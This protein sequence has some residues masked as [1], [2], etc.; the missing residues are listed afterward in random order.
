MVFLQSSIPIES[1][2]LPPIRSP[3]EFSP[4]RGK[5]PEAGP[6]RAA[7][8]RPPGSSRQ[9]RGRLGG[10]ASAHLGTAAPPYVP[11]RPATAVGIAIKRVQDVFRMGALITPAPRQPFPADA[12]GPR[13]SARAESS[14]RIAPSSRTRHPAAL[15]L[16][17]SGARAEPRIGARNGVQRRSWRDDS[18][19][20]F[21]SRGP[22]AFPVSPPP[23][24]VSS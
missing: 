10:L 8:A 9:H 3:S 1:L 24:P 19:P 18:D 17:A 5:A 4:N 7:G 2:R 23:N 22:H 15:G 16:R 21:P 13:D 20:A 14:G 12:P 11:P 6:H